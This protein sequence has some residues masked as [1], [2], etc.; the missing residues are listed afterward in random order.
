WAPPLPRRIPI[1]AMGTVPPITAHA[2]TA[3]ARPAA[4][5]GGG[6]R[7]GIATSA[8]SAATNPAARPAN[9]RARS[10]QTGAGLRLSWAVHL[11]ERR[12]NGPSP[13]GSGRVRQ[14]EPVAVEAGGGSTISLPLGRRYR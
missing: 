10:G 4:A 13:H 12:L 3:T 11:R 1:T 8:S 2:T 9:P 7:A 6:R 5:I 14:V